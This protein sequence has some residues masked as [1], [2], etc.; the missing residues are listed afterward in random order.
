MGDRRLLPTA[1]STSP[2]GRSGRRKQLELG[3]LATGGLAVQLEQAQATDVAE[4]KGEGDKASMRVIYR[5]GEVAAGGC[6]GRPWRAQGR[7]ARRGIGPSSGRGLRV[8]G[9]EAGG[10][11]RWPARR[12]PGE[13][14]RRQSRGGRGAEDKGG[15]EEEEREQAR[16]TSLKFSESSRASQ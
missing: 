2:E 5:G 4:Q 3:V 10:G 8:E 16:R 1:T 13:L 6:S 15:A 9:G 7:T 11:Q 12:W 14:H